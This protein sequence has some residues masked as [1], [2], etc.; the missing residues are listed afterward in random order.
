ML[1][2]GPTV[3]PRS[4]E[5]P[6]LLVV[7]LHGWGADGDDLIDLADPFGRA[8]PDA[9]FVA[10]HGPEPC[11]LAPFGRQWFS[12]RQ[13]DPHHLLEGVD[14]AATLLD[15]FLQEQ[16]RRLGLT[17]G[18]I[19]LFGFSQGAMLALH[20][21]LTCQA[22]TLAGE[23]HPTQDR[24][25]AAVVAFSGRL[26]SKANGGPL[27]PLMAPPMLLVH[28]LDDEVVPVGHLQEAETRLRRLGCKVSSQQIEGLGHGINQKGI[29]LARAFL[30]THLGS[31]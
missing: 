3:A 19:A 30:L 18:Q 27:P 22:E 21:A 9:A 13:M 16:R 31:K 29:D 23:G 7:L 5:D 1:L 12:L 14:R 28:G 10:P 26:L 4:G 8:L 24:C 11:D 6:K 2:S 20:H 25:V 15:G 17:F